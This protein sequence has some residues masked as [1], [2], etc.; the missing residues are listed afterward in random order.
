MESLKI[1][2]STSVCEPISLG[3]ISAAVSMKGLFTSPKP[4]KLLAVP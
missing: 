3:D 1:I 2:V 4:K